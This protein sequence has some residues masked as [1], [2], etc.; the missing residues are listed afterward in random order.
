MSITDEQLKTKE[1]N[2]KTQLEKNYLILPQEEVFPKFQKYEGQEKVQALYDQYTNVDAA[3]YADYLSFDDVTVKPEEPVC[4]QELYA[5]LDGVVQ[6]ILTNQNV[7]LDTLI[8][9]AAHDFQVN[10]LD[11]L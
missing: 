5:V 7:D 8:S 4:C 1:E 10:H 3:D 6:E 2:I 9:S 11:N